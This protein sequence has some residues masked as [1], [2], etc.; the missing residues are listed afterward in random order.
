MLCQLLLTLVSVISPVILMLRTY[1]FSGRKKKV[2]VV[3]SITFLTLSGVMIWVTSKQLSRLFWNLVY[4]GVFLTLRW[5]HSVFNLL[6]SQTQRLFCHFGSTGFRW[7]P[8]RC[9]TWEEGRT[10]AL[11]LSLR[12]ACWTFGAHVW[13]YWHEILSLAQMLSVRCYLSFI[14]SLAE[15][16]YY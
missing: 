14:I 8:V 5:I 3:L 7:G 16:S 12:S 6:D 4:E 11:C 15:P 10:G 2:L 1:A 9:S 13:L